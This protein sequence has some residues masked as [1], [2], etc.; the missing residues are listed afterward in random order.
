MFEDLKG[1]DKEIAQLTLYGAYD[2]AASKGSRGQALSDKELKAN[3]EALG[4]G[5]PAQ[6]RLRL[7]NS[8]ITTLLTNFEGLR[9]GSYGTIP[10]VND[11][12]EKMAQGQPY[13]IDVE[14]Y[15]KSRLEENTFYDG[16][17]LLQQLEKVRRGD[18][19]VGSVQG[20]GNEDTTA[21]P[22]DAIEKLKKLYAEAPSDEAR[23]KLKQQF[24][25]AARR[26]GAADSILGE[27]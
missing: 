23:Q 25:S 20:G 27:E 24:D 10:W 8:A 2:L 18:T 17:M 26:V 12:H 16:Q 14:T 6:K 4:V 9:K 5:L 13:T 21:M 15:V 19:T 7:I 22:Q 11:K 3:L 1:V